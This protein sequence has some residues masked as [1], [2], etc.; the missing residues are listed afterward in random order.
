MSELPEGWT[1]CKVD[2]IFE[3]FS[4]GTPSKSKASY[5]TGKIPWISSG[6]FNSNLINEGTEFISKDGLEN[7]SAKLCRPGSVIVV[8]RSGILKHTLPVAIVGKELAINQD[9]KCFDSGDDEINRWLFLS[10]KKSAREILSLNRE[11]TTVQS[12]KYDTLKEHELVLPPPS[13]QR[14][15]IAKLE[16]LLSRVNAA[17]QRLATIPRILK[18]FRQSV[19]AAAC[20][21]RLTADWR[22]THYE[23]ETGTDLLSRILKERYLK[24]IGT[25]RTNKISQYLEPATADQSSLPDLPNAWATT[26]IEAL[27]RDD[28]ALSYGIL[29][30]GEYNPSGIPMLRVMDIGDGKLND[31]KIFRVTPSLAEEYKRT[32]L[33]ANDIL[34][35][36]MA[37]VGRSMVVPAHLIGA[38]VNRA[39]AV[40]RLTELIDASFACMVIRSPHFQDVFASEK[41]GSAQLRINL[42]DLRRFAFPLPP[43]AEQQEIVRRVE[44]L[45]KTTDALEA[46][47][48][49]AKAHIDKLTQS[50]LAKGFR[51]ELVPQDPN[52]EP[53]SVLLKR[54]EQDSLAQGKGGKKVTRNDVR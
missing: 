38:N 52:D 5:W 18:R 3:S 1:T 27:L 13:E 49:S 32:K 30:P 20:S 53:A 35:A 17:Q 54:I 42:G 25:N 21:G 51:G 40:L 26:T 2:Q 10:L 15:I 41:I 45:F 31:T 4:G 14:R 8:V 47:Y 28:N 36:V 34:L 37:T 11:G 12:V 23:I 48:R 46:R 43:L 19:L 29:K 39:L 44:A 22:A 33:K 6:E 9:I 24:W 7:S 16:K 50:I